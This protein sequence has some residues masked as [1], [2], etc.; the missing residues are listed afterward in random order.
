MEK[1]SASNNPII[2]ILIY[3]MAGGGAE[4]FVSYLLKFLI[5]TDYKVHLIL[6]NT[7]IE[8]DVP[9]QVEIH[10]LEESSETENNLAKI[11]KIPFLARRYSK[12]L[13]SLKITHSFSLLSRP[14]YI[15][16]LSKSLFGHDVNL[17]MLVCFHPSPISYP[18]SQFVIA[19]K[20]KSYI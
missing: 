5:N 9:N 18:Y 16:V 19:T 11:I 12:L 6:M 7:T 14:N 4:R 17:L 2:G 3:S 20:K 10:Y 15:N 8:F 1:V 13:K